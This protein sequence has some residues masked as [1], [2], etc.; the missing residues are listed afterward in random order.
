M[1]LAP[2]SP[3]TLVDRI[4]E[5]IVDGVY[6]PRERLVEAD[7]AD[8]YDAKRSAIRAALLELTAEGLVEREP[9]RGARVRG[10]TVEE[11]IE[12]AQVRQELESL[13]ARLAAE[14]GT[15]AERDL[16]RVRVDELHSAHAAQDWLR[17]LH[18]NAGFHTAIIEMARH[19]TAREIIARLGNLNLGRHFPMALRSP[20][21]TESEVEHEHIAAAII[22]GDADEA[23]MA[24]RAHLQIS[25]DVLEAQ[26]RANEAAGVQRRAGPRP[27]WPAAV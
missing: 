25:I 6:H 2:D 16:L 20:P 3:L 23:S 10:L 24:M 15:A 11:G 27:P 9:N 7:L 8:R 4:R 13:C 21:A 1:S 5:D 26:L 12:I 18:A 14:R 17:Y 22:R 19:E